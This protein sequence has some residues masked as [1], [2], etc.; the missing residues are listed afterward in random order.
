M[1]YCR[2]RL[3]GHEVHMVGVV[4]QVLQLE[5]QGS[6]EVLS[7]SP[8]TMVMSGGQ[9]STHLKSRRFLMVLAGHTEQMSG[10]L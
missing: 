8:L 7:P 5:S 6:H 1:L 4:S 10:V 2:V 9:V 3:S